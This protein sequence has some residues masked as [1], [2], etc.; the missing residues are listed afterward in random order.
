MRDSCFYH[1]SP[2][3]DFIPG[4]PVDRVLIRSY[5]SDMSLEGTPYEPDYHE[6]L[7][8]C[9]GEKNLKRLRSRRDNKLIPLLRPRP[10]RT[11]RSLSREP[12]YN[13]PPTPISPR[14]MPLPPL[15]DR[16][17]GTPPTYEELVR[18]GYISDKLFSPLSLS[19]PRK[20]KT[21]PRKRKTSPRKR[22]TS[23]R[24]RK[25]SPRKRKT[26]PRKRKTFANR[27]NKKK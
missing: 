9:T 24:K 17:L 19:Y 22:K 27:R 11:L 4:K 21:S 16:T 7:K 2:K 5:V 13:G 12:I 18:N 26:S 25:T 14:D 23:P 6:L 10:E 3:L 20:R 1:Y 8:L 15:P